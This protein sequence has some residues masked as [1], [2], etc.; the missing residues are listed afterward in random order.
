MNVTLGSS[1]CCED[2]RHGEIED[3]GSRIY[4]RWRTELTEEV[5]FDQNSNLCVSGSRCLGS[6]SGAP[7]HHTVFFVACR[8]QIPTRAGH[9]G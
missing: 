2:W 9:V 6:G 7:S 8:W 3:D 5:T 1:N 4:F